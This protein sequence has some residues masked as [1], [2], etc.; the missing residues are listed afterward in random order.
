M[1]VG[2][3][4]LDFSI[5]SLLFVIVFQS[6]L[7][8][9]TDHVMLLHI[10]DFLIDLLP[11]SFWIQLGVYSVK[12]CVNNFFLGEDFYRRLLGRNLFLLL[13]WNKISLF[14]LLLISLRFV[15]LKVLVI[16]VKEKVVLGII[17][18]IIIILFFL[19]LVKSKHILVVDHLYIKIWS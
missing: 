12:L 14:Q 18:L 11:Q 8:K 10:R 3:G 17:Y 4:I 9:I 15:I 16:V 1:I 13:W 19:E 2:L 5:F 7:F 6:T